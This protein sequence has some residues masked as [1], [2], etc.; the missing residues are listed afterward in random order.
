VKIDAYRPDVPAE[1]LDRV[2]R[3]ATVVGN[4]D[5]AESATSGATGVE[6]RLSSDAQLMQTVMQGAQDALNIRHDVVARMQA[7]LANGTV[8]NDAHGLADAI[9]DRLTGTSSQ[10]LP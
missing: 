10:K 8:G 9:L 1:T 7:A 5:G 6:L 4:R 2:G 3:P